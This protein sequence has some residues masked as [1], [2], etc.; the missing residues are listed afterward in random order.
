MKSS[1]MPAIVRLTP[2]VAYV[3]GRLAVGWHY[4]KWLKNGRNVQIF[5]GNKADRFAAAAPFRG[6]CRAGMEK[7]FQL[8]GVKFYWGSTR[9]SRRRGAA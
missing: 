1:D 7:S 4:V 8:A 6:N 3:P 9:T 5:V 2:L